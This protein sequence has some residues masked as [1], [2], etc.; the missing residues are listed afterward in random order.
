MVAVFTAGQANHDAVAFFN[1][2]EV[3]NGFAHVTAQTLLQFI[4]VV[5]LFLL[6][7]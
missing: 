1:H 6:I 2:V 4:Q 7:S 3:C 5:L